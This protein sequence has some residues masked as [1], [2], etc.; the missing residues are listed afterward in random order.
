MKMFPVLWGYRVKDAIAEM[1]AAG[2]VYFPVCIPW[3]MLTPHAAQAQTN[4]SQTLARL[5]ERGGLSVS[6]AI[7]VLQDRRHRSMPL[8]ESNETL[9]RLIARWIKEQEAGAG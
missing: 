5:A 2:S 6:E 8:V 7:A 4:H 1:Q 9:C 3:D